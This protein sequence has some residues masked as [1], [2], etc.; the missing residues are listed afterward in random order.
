V[1]HGTRQGVITVLSLPQVCEVCGGKGTVLIS[2]PKASHSAVVPC[3][4]H[5]WGL[6]I[7]HLPMRSEP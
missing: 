7:V 3:L 5:V 6:P 4:H 1:T 2:A